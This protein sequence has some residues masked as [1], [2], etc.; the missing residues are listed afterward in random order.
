MIT[1]LRIFLSI[2]WLW[3]VYVVVAT[4]LESNLMKEWP[5]LSSIPWMRATLWDFYGNI[6]VIYVWL[7]YKEKNN[8]KCAIWLVAFIT[9]GSIASIG[10]L[11]LQLFMVKS[12]ASLKEIFVAND[13][14]VA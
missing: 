4:S 2:V 1:F 5:F 7:C 9:L 14:I 13:E 10:Y 11:I 3:M 6:L 8:F 12:S